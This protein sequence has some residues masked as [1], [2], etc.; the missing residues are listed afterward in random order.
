M[1]MPMVWRFFLSAV[2]LLNILVFSGAQCSSHVMHKVTY[3]RTVDTN[4]PEWIFCS[5]MSVSS[6]VN[7]NL[8]VPVYVLKAK[9]KDIPSGK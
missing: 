2:A 7:G 4:M 3:V 9:N 1:P 5:L 6:A 8:E